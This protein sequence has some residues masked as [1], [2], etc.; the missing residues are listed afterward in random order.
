DPCSFGGI[1]VIA[2]KEM[3]RFYRHVLIEH[4]FPHHGA[5]AFQHAGKTIYDAFKMLG[6]CPS[7]ILHNRAAGDRYP[8]ENPF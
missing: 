4:K 8:T 5:L 6:V 3:A 2:V 7:R 1:G